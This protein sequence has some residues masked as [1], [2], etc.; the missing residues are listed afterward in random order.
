MIENEKEYQE[1]LD[2]VR[3]EYMPHNPTKY[4]DI[5]REERNWRMEGRELERRQ[6]EAKFA[7]S[8]MAGLLFSMFFAGIFMGAWCLIL[9][10]LEKN[11]FPS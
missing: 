8:L 11:N 9:Y 2:R 6:K 4:F 1:F 10:F 3:N 5:L 7:N